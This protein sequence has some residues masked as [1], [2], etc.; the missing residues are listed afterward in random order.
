MAASFESLAIADY[1][2]KNKKSGDLITVD[3]VTDILKFDRP[4]VYWGLQYVKRH[5]LI[6]RIPKP[7]INRGRVFLVGVYRVC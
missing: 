3:E 6:E 5:N 2:R 4:K 7:G 1:I